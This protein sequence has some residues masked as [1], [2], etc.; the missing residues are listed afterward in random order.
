MVEADAQAAIRAFG[1]AMQGVEI[2][3]QVADPS[4]AV[5]A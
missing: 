5:A 4:E 1:A 2:Q 3:K